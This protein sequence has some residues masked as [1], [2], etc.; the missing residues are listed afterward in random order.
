MASWDD[1]YVK[2]QQTIYTRWVNQKLSAR[3][4]PTMTDVLKDLGQDD[5]LSNLVTALSEKEMPKPAKKEKRVVKA[6]K[7]DWISRQLDFVFSCGVEM[8]LK[9]S[10][11]NI[12]E[13]DSKDIM[14]L[15]YAIMLKFLKFDDDDGD[16]AGNAKDALLRWCQFHTKGFVNVNVTNLTKSWSD[17]LALCALVAKFN[18]DSINFTS[19]EPSNAKVN[20]ATAMDAAEKYFKVEK[21]LEPDDILTLT[22]KTDGEKAMLVVISEYYYGINDWFKRQLA[23]KRITKV[24]VFTRQNDER[25]SKYAADGA[26]VLERLDASEKLLA[27]VATVD[28]TMAGAVSRLEDFNNYKANQKNQLTKQFLEMMGN[29]DTLQLRLANNGRPTFAPAAEMTPEALQ[30]RLDALEAKEAIEPKLYL[31]LSRQHKLVKL[32]GSH[33]VE[34]D[35]L[36]AWLAEQTASLQEP[37]T[38]SSTGDARK[39]L[40]L[41]ESLCKLIQQKKDVAFAA[42]KSISAELD[43]EK[44]ENITAPRERESAID[45]SFSVVDE[46]VVKN[47]P[48]LEDNLAREKFKDEVMMKVDVHDDIHKKLIAWVA[49]KDEYYKTKETIA[50]VLEARLQL[51][52]LDG[53]DKEVSDMKDGNVSRLK[54]LGNEI[55]SAKHQTDLSEWSHPSPTDVSALEMG[56]DETFEDELG[57]LSQRKRAVLDDDLAR[58]QLIEKVN[59]WVGTH[60]AK[61]ADVLGWGAK[62]QAYLE[63]KET[64]SSSAEAKFHLSVLEAYDTERKT[65]EEGDIAALRALGTSI[66]SETYKT[67]HSEWVYGSPSDIDELETA[68]ADM[69]TKLDAASASKRAILEDD[70]ARELYAEQTRLLAGQHID[71]ALQ[72]ARWAT[73]KATELQEDINVHSIREAQV[74]LSVLSSYEAE[75]IRFTSTAVTSLKELG[76]TVLARSY[77][78][79]LS[80]YVYETPSEVSERET[81]IDEQWATL[82]ELLATRRKTLDQLLVRETRKEELRVDFADA[83]G[84]IVNFCSDSVAL[85]GTAEDQKASFGST[86]QEVEAREAVL[87]AE[88]SALDA[89]LDALMAESKKMV[90]EM[91]QLVRDTEAFDQAQSDADGDGADTAASTSPQRVAELAVPVEESLSPSPKSKRRSRFGTLSKSIKKAFG[92]SKARSQRKR[93]QLAALREAEATSADAG[94]VEWP[95]VANP[96]TQLSVA[97]ERK[98]SD[99][100]KAAQKARQDTYAA[101]LERWREDDAKCKEFAELVNPL[102]DSAKQTMDSLTGGGVDEEK[103]LVAVNTASDDLIK[104]AMKLPDAKNQEAKIKAR[105]ILVNPYTV[106]TAE[107]VTCSL[108]M[109]ELIAAQKKP[110]LEAM[111]EYKKFKGISPEQYAEME[112]LFK[113]YDKDNS[114]SISEKELRTCLFS[115]GEERSKTETKDF[116]KKFAKGKKELNFEQFRELMMNLIGDMGTPDG[117]L[118]SFKVLSGGHDVITVEQLSDFVSSAD[119]SFFEE[120]AP[121]A[122]RADGV[123][124]RAFP[125]WVDAVC[126]R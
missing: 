106:I 115:L 125:A 23:G 22:K 28:N 114:G 101:E 58:E 118:E 73:G 37:I 33:T 29:F 93:A 45:S 120:E 109:V 43:G 100:L 46:L 78:T 110:H 44:Y 66:K 1:S 71:K 24:V 104:H 11:G 88:D 86:L 7:L 20:F 126:K 69:T 98:S 83:A 75:K 27:D 35:K 32:H 54:E 64:V 61:Q 13:G 76:A 59:N 49:I 119:I 97:I 36:A 52:T 4:F 102:Q 70:L 38:C 99:E 105:G 95:E 81:E 90:D 48:V 21:F 60:K 25:R 63:V 96:Y 57:P 34:A 15:V 53:V 72:C 30:S 77:K 19:L 14:G 50:G 65:A 31:E 17:G 92:K 3:L 40:K 117:L 39:Q 79:E 116:M 12:Y 103:L 113:D 42:V 85:M 5:H 108:E 68:V 107:T 2:L 84:R 80:E 123:A 62:K 87:T 55:R 121:S 10:P 26:Q 82:D 18:P 74:L 41:F 6:Q 56:I 67:E 94:D 122:E 89:T 111:I 51:S 91:V 124:G 47:R 9:P 8:K 112:T 16:S